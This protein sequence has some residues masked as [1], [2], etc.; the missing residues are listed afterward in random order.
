MSKTAV[1]LK[2]EGNKAFSSGDFPSAVELYSKAIELDDKQPAFFT[3]RAQVGDS[4]PSHA[5]VT[6]TSS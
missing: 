5:R 6:T 1:E 3:N 2:N 4:P